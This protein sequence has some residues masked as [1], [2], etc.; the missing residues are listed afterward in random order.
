[1]TRLGSAMNDAVPS[2]TA[3]APVGERTIVDRFYERVRLHPERVALRHRD[4][5]GWRDITWAQ[6]GRNVARAGDGLRSLGLRPGDRMAL[7][8]S[9]RPEWFF[10]DIA[11]MAAGGITA[12]IY[13]SSSP[14]QAAHVVGHSGAVVAVVENGEQLAKL[15]ARRSVLAEL[16]AVV[17]MDPAE[18]SLDAEVVTWD[19]LVHA[20][21]DGGGSP[22]SPGPSPEDIATFVYTSGTTGAPKAVMLSHRNIAWTCESLDEHLQMGD[23]SA[24]RALS[25][26]P[27]SHIAER[28]VSHLLQIHYGSQT[29]FAR[30][31]DTLREDLVACR[32]TYFFGVPR[33]WEKFHAA[34]LE[35]L[36]AH[37]SSLR[38][39]VEHAMLR[40][41]LSAGERVVDARQEAVARGLPAARA[42][43]GMRLRLEHALLEKVVLAKARARAGLDE[44]TRAFSSAAALDADVVRF[45]HA[46]GL[47]LAEGYGQSEVCGP[48]T[49]NPPHAIRIGT[50]G[51]PIPGLEMRIAD[52]GEILVRG[53][54]VTPGYFADE[55]ATAALIDE[56]GWMRSGDIGHVDDNGYLTVTDR[57]K[58]LIITSGG[59]NIAPQE[60][61]NRLAAIDVV[62][63]VVVVGDGRPFL[64]A[65][66]TLDG[67]TAAEW[68]RARGLSD[69]PSRLA[70]E[71]A[72]WEEI[73][74]GIDRFNAGVSRAEG[75]KKFRVLERDFLQ[76]RDE[77]TPTLKV[78]RRSVAARYAAAIEEM[79]APGSP[80][81]AAALE[82]QH[83]TSTTS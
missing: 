5:H 4:E 73:R 11:C 48:T 47:E 35:R 18:A 62:A 70:R 81:A 71:P 22:R 63:N 82:A 56:E 23:M 6:Y 27:L 57:K 49:W 10:A 40:R 43:L 67:A 33:V 39:R 41:A 42:D 26:L 65:L 72:L 69:D 59:K 25:Y 54:N 50:V 79:Y 31:I 19:D 83:E 2:A 16:R 58:D 64:G 45:F 77:I 38:E 8:S 24:G 44:C 14:D 52:D 1:M 74:A 20:G 9:N 68:G 12:P 46:L 55:D 3:R 7:L 37:P 30:S 75:V 34:V 13:T 76:E 53:G 32:P 78:K 80:D 17:V 66:V 51:T 21:A 36:R 29:W 60:I 61:E 15:A 28:M